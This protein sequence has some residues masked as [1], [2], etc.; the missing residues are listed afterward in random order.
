MLF[1]YLQLTF[2][3]FIQFR[4]YLPPLLVRLLCYTYPFSLIFGLIWNLLCTQPTSVLA[5]QAS[6]GNKLQ[7]LIVGV[8]R[9][10]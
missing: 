9:L 2:F 6:R 1:A 10:S 5:H 8:I 3:D 7:G 4:D